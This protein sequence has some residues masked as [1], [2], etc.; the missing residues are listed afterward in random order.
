MNQADKGSGV[1]QQVAAMNQADGG[2]G[3]LQRIAAMNK[4]DMENLNESQDAPWRNT[5]ANGILTN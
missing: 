2:S 4:A 5:R 1:L 3:V